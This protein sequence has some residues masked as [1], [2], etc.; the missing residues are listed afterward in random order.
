MM[1]KGVIFDI[2]EMSI[3]DGPGVRTTIFFKGCPLRC[4]WCHNPEGFSPVPQLKQSGPPCTECGKCYDPCA[5]DDCSMYGR[6]L[7]ICPL[8][9]LSVSGYEI[10]SFDISEKVKRQAAFLNST[11]G[12]I[13]ISGGEPLMQPKFLIDLLSVMK[14]LHVAVETSAYSDEDIFREMVERADLVI[15][16]IKHMNDTVHR[17]YTGVG[18]GQI[19]SNLSVLMRSECPF[20]IRIP[21]IPRVNDD[22]ENLTKTADFLK[23]AKNLIGVEL[24]PYNVLAGAKYSAVGMKYTPAFDTAAKPN[25]DCTPFSKQGIPC[26]VL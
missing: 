11:G 13:T 4:S 24:M 12:G 21:V 1:A 7:H 16:D 5:H 26:T 20:I 8:G 14:P 10:D 19:L 2:K 9:R 3:H 17:R 15:A 18:N 22:M 23:A 6:C 25:T